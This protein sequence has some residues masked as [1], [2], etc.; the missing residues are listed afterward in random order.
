MDNKL[1]AE[2]DNWILSRGLRREK[3]LIRTANKSCSDQ[4]MNCIIEN[5]YIRSGLYLK[6]PD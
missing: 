2:C 3:E 6:Y 1:K 4:K 5:M